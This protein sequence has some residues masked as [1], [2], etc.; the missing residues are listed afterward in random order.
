MVGKITEP[1]SRGSDEDDLGYC[2]R[3]NA[4]HHA[5]GTQEAHA[6]GAHGTLAILVSEAAAI[7]I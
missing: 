6:P 7:E 2:L 1:V 5:P 4:C 3:G